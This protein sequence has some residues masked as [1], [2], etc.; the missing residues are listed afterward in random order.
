M[1]MSS[2][3]PKGAI[4][5]MVDFEDYCI[6]TYSGKKELVKWIKNEEALKIILDELVTNDDLRNVIIYWQKEYVEIN[7]RLES[8]V[9]KGF[10]AVVPK[11]DN[12]LA[13][14]QVAGIKLFAKALEMRFPKEYR[15]TE[16]QAS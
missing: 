11:A 3:S 7:D 8:L 13:E 6:I 15:E 14:K 5:E 4:R 1:L 2:V 10:L 9:K 16:T 12:H